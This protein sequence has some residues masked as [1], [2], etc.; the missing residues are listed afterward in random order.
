MS[1]G[2]A[3][4]TVRAHDL[5]PHALAVALAHL[6]ID[7]GGVLIRLLEMPFGLLQVVRV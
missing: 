4:G 1:F 7:L 5:L 3:N 6:S 2:Y